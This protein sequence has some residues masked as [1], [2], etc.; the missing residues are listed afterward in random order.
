MISDLVGIFDEME[1]NPQPSTVCAAGDVFNLRRWYRLM[2][3]ALMAAQ[4]RRDQH[5]ARSG[6]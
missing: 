6:S 4:Q 3:G 2:Q 1:S 5:Q